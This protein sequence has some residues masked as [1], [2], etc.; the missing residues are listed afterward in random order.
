LWHEQVNQSIHIIPAK[1]DA[2][3]GGGFWL[4]IIDPT[5]QPTAQGC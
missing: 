2:A 5:Q 4:H 1:E 3:R